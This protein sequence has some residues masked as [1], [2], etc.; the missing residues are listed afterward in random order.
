[1]AFTSV[2]ARA[3]FDFGER[4]SVRRL[5]GEQCLMDV[6]RGEA[7]GAANENLAS[8]F[9]PFENGAGADAKLAANVNGDGDLALRGEFGV[10]QGHDLHY[11]GN[12]LWPG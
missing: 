1:M 11:H 8:L 3:F 4:A 6:F 5:S 9:V 12:E 10:R 7:A 2:A